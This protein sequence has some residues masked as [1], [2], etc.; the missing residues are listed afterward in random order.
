MKALE[1]WK[2]ADVSGLCWGFSRP[3]SFHLPQYP[4]ESRKV[5]NK[6]T[7]REAWRFLD[8]VFRG[9]EYRESRLEPI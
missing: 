8:M 9:Q 1:H 4:D 3:I 5:D 7:P 2:V 6:V